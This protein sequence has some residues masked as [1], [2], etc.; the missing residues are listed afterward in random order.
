M[1]N[2][3][4][5][6]LAAVTMALMLAGIISASM[7]TAAAVPYGYAPASLTWSAPPTFA[8][9]LPADGGAARYPR[10][11]SELDVWARGRDGSPRYRLRQRGRCFTH[12]RSRYCR[13]R[14]SPRTRRIT[15]AYD[16]ARYGIVVYGWRS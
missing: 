5:F 10:A 13:V 2:R 1:F 8:V 12:A 11:V 3:S 14:Y 6:A 4:P 9:S 16:A 15:A 7:S